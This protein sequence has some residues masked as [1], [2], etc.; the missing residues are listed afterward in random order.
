MLVARHH[1]ALPLRGLHGLMPKHCRSSPYDDAIFLA[2]NLSE[3]SRI[4]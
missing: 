4:L 3:P 1:D 2:P